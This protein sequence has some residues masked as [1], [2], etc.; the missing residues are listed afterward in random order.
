MFGAFVAMIFLQCLLASCMLEA[1]GWAE[2][3]ITIV[4]PV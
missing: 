1:T 4:I 3:F 2:A